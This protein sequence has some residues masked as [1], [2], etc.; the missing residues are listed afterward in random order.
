VSEKESGESRGV[1]SNS[2]VDFRPVLMAQTHGIAEE[3]SGAFAL[4]ALPLLRQQPRR[5]QP[6][7]LPARCEAGGF[8]HRG[9]FRPVLM[10]QTHG[11]AEEGSG[12]FAL[13]ALPLLRQQPRRERPGTFLHVVRRVGFN[14]EAI[15]DPY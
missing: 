2:R 9:D 12:A 3:G 15:S 13:C 6:R 10:A 5:Q 11:I 1:G 14:T 4:C 7:Y 8:Q